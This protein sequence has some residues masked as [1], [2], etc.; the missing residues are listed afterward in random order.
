MIPVR[1]QEYRGVEPVLRDCVGFPSL[2]SKTVSGIF[3]SPGVT[4]IRV[5][6]L[7]GL[8]KTLGQRTGSRIVLRELFLR[9]I[10][11][12]KSLIDTTGGYQQKEISARHRFIVDKDPVSGVSTD[13]S[14]IYNYPSSVD[15]YFQF[16]NF[17]NDRY[18][19]FHAELEDRVPVTYKLLAE[20]WALREPHTVPFS[21]FLG[22]LQIPVHYGDDAGTA[23]N[24][25]GHRLLWNLQF[26][27]PLPPSY[28]IRYYLKIVFHDI[29]DGV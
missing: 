28:E 29:P 26:N 7:D 17:Q 1:W 6:L 9:G 19:Y 3:T 5:G 14:N 2:K 4:D 22:N 18:E 16:L 12:S 8:S 27:F 15:R 11:E 23:N 13:W 21:I 25:T 20:N 10:I 24:I